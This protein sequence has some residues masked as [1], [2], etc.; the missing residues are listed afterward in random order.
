[1]ADPV[2]G[3]CLPACNP[4]VYSDF[5]F[6]QFSCSYNCSEMLMIDNTMIGYNTQNIT[7]PRKPMGCAARH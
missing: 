2:A 7:K 5:L 6:L 1:M 3:L 4:L